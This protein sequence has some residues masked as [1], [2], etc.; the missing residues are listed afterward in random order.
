MD[1][2]CFGKGTASK[3]KCKVPE[4]TVPECKELHAESL[5][6]VIVGEASAINIIDMTKVTRKKGLLTQQGESTRMR[7]TM[8]GRPQMFLAGL[9]GGG[10]REH[11]P[12]E[13]NR[14]QLGQERKGGGCNDDNQT[15][16]EKDNF[17]GGKGAAYSLPVRKRK[18]C[19][20]E[21]KRG[22]RAK[23]QKLSEGS[24]E[25]WETRRKERLR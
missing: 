16:Q 15:P 19:E 12:G 1:T 23:R 18:V 2:G 3:P 14:Q 24:D 9:G 4:C 21:V 13:H 7:M 8:G 25:E 22:R 17:W 6:N 11:F 5:H 10:A 20:E